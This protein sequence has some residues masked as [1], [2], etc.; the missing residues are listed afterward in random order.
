MVLMSMPCANKAGR[1]RRHRH[2]RQVPGR[3]EEFN[4]LDV[5][6]RLA[7]ATKARSYICV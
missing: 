2:R 6:L 4:D 1:S 3:P 5:A 7:A